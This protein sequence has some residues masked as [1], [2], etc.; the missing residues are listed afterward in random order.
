MWLTALESMLVAL[1]VSRAFP[2]S[3]LYNITDES[4]TQYVETQ[5]ETLCQYDNDNNEYDSYDSESES[6]VE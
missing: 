4:T 2:T 6:E 5:L 3:E 1:L